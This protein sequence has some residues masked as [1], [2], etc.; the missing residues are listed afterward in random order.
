MQTFKIF[1]EF[2]RT[3]IFSLLNLKYKMNEPKNCLFLNSDDL[4]NYNVKL[5]K[6]FN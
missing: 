2:I 5:V 1:N 3:Q 6:M 4:Y